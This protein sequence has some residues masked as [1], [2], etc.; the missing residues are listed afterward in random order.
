MLISSSTP[1]KP[2]SCSLPNG[3]SVKQLSA[4]SGAS[5]VPPYPRP[6]MLPDYILPHHTPPPA[7][8]PSITVNAKG[9]AYP[10]KALLHK[11]GLRAGQ[12]ID[13]LPPSADCPIWQL[14]LRPTAPRHVEWYADNSPRIRSL[15]LPA[16]LVQPGAPLTLTLPLTPPIG[17]SLYQLLP[18]VLL[19]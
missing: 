1:R 7:P 16:G 4:A 9:W 2:P 13:L 19:P 18:P 15:K 5:L 8:L 14:D 6:A 12:P 3:I 17:P 10:S 11:L